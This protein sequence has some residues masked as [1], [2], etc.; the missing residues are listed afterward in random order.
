MQFFV[1]CCKDRGYGLSLRVQQECSVEIGLAMS[2]PDIE[3]I[4][5]AHL[6]KCSTHVIDVLDLRRVLHTDHCW[7]KP[8]NGSILLVQR[9]VFCMRLVPK[10]PEGPWNIGPG[11]EPR[12][13]DVAERKVSPQR[14]PQP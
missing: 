7:A 11:S 3:T 12:A 2:A 13:G 6:V 4:L 10:N 8:H 9:D 5:G 14:V 1:L